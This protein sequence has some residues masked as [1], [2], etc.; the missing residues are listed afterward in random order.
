MEFIHLYLLCVKFMPYLMTINEKIAA[1]R[2]KMQENHLDAY[3]IPSSDPHQSEYVAPHWK[4]REWISGFNGSA[5]LVIITA[6][7]AGLWTDSRYFIQ[8]E[9]QLAGS[10]MVLHQ[11]KVPHAP[12]HI[13]WLKEQLPAKARVGCNGLFFS[14]GQIQ[15]LV[16]QLQQKNIQI[17]Y[18]HQLIDEIWQD[19]PPLPLDSI[20]EHDLKF[21]GKSRLEKLGIIRAEMKK[22]D[23]SHY[24]V[25]TLDDICWV[26]NIRGR[27]VEYNPVC[28]CHLLIGLEKAQLF[29]ALKKVPEKVKT[30]LEADGIQLEPYL[31]ADFFLE[32][33]SD[34]STVL[35][36]KGSINV[37]L[38]DALVS[39]QMINGPN[40]IRP[41][42]AIKNATEIKHIKNAMIKDA[43]ALTKLFRWLEKT[44]AQRSI[45]EVEVAK[46]LA[47]FRAEEAD[48]FGESFAAIVGYQGNGAIVHYRAEAHT[49]AQIRPEGILLLDSGGQYQDGTTDITRTIALSEPT[50]VQKRHYTAVLKGHIALATIRFPDT[51]M[52]AQLDTLARMYLWQD[53][54]NYGHGTGHGVGFFLNVHE[55][56]QGFA[57]S[58]VTSRGS[59]IFKP[60]MFTSNEPG[61]YKSGAYGIRIENLVLCVEDETNEWGRFLKFE[62]FTLFPIDK[63]LIDTQLLTEGELAWLNTYH[64]KVWEALSPVLDEESKEWMR[65]KCAVIY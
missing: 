47:T 1:L 30:N 39:K 10:E 48:Y 59:T 54:L 3:L 51:T 22:L 32:A 2:I 56:P 64:K 17:D 16:N 28:I 53:A 19:R 20:F 8:A 43:S 62:T 11:Q 24:L 4:S 5:G 40:L 23:A 52:G 46:Q 18:Q 25:T 26:L 35:V 29:I 21:A 12:E 57:P 7:H 65:E 6:D 38:F 60:G 63:K 33:L 27:D 34:N 45:P 31:A 13:Q 50:A 9:E 58:A 14:K 44:V 37:R 41:V 55:P 61:F 15:Y 42:K 36:D 49:C